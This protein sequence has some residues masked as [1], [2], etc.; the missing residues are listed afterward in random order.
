MF[1]L[2]YKE[3]QSTLDYQLICHMGLQQDVENA[4]THWRSQG[5]QVQSPLPYAACF[6]SDVANEL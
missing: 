2:T 3:A 1:W 6:S 5:G 4:I